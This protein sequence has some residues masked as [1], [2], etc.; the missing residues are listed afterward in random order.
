MFIATSTSTEITSPPPPPPKLPPP[1]APPVV[2]N[3]PSATA[4][5]SAN[6]TNSRTSAGNGRKGKDTDPLTHCNVCDTPGTNQNLVMCD[7]C[8]KCYHFS[9]LDPP[10]KK[11][12]KRRGYSWHCADCDPSASES[13]T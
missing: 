10:V 7:E 6:N 9:C 5:V 2:S 4:N 11:S 13:E 12:P 1:P 3:T 8:K